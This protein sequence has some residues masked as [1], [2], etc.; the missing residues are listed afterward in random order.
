MS[1]AL[2]S[3]ALSLVSMWKPMVARIFPAVMT[4]RL[5]PI[6]TMVDSI[7]SRVSARRRRAAGTSVSSMLLSSRLALVCSSLS[8]LGGGSSSALWRGTALPFC[9]CK[10]RG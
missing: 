2:R 6:S 5:M 3:K 8:K 10:C 4:M 1:S 9:S 7:C